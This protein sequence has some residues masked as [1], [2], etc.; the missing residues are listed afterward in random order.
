MRVAGSSLI[1][2]GR[3]ALEQEP[4]DHHQIRNPAEPGERRIELLK[5]DAHQRWMIRS[6]SLCFAAVTLRIY[7]GAFFALGVPFEQFYTA[8]AW[9][10]W[11]PNLVV[12]DWFLLKR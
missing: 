4:V 5:W 9:L 8:L 7:L 3:L 11:V 10:C 6:F 1:N 2:Q 12:V